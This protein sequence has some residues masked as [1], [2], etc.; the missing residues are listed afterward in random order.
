MVKAQSIKR[1]GFGRYAALTTFAIG[2]RPP[3]PTAASRS[4][5]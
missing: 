1:T 3:K 2:M 5:W 4:W